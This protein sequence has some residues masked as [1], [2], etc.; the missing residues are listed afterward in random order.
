M[1]TLQIFMWGCMHCVA[2]DL[3]ADSQVYVLVAFKLNIVDIRFFFEGSKIVLYLRFSELHKNSMTWNASMCRYR[4]A[5]TYFTNLGGPSM[6]YHSPKALRFLNRKFTCCSVHH[7]N[8]GALIAAEVNI[9]GARVYR[10]YK[11][12][13]V[14][15]YSLICIYP[16]VD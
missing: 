5:L 3:F 9:E 7:Y 2:S 15:T 14:Y 1:G 10:D 4:L 16:R 13:H 12:S 6:R 8:R 11:L